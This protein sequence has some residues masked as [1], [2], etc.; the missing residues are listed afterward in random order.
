MI[1]VNEIR[2]SVAKFGVTSTVHDLALRTANRLL[3][4]KVFKGFVGERLAPSFLLCPPPYRRQFLDETMLRAFA[5]DP[6]TGL[7]AGFLD[8]ALSKGDECYGILDGDGRLA[9]Y[10]WYARTPTRIDPPKLRLF[11]GEHYIYMYKAYTDPR[12][13]GK[14]LLALAI[15]GALK[16]YQQLGYQGLVAYVESNN[17][18]SLQSCRQLGY[19]AFGTIVLIKL[20]GRFLIL[21][22]AGCRR[23]GLRIEPVA[24]DGSDRHH[25]PAGS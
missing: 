12:H 21:T 20:F 24:A 8:E 10:G 23:F 1:A 9:S 13:R 3:L 18:S 7:S 4:L 14:K 22:S 5:L 2:N 16:H 11:F 25:P 17:L 19:S 15:T 6:N